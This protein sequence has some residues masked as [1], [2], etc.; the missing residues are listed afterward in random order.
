TAN[1]LED[2]DTFFQEKPSEWALFDTFTNQDQISQSKEA[3]NDK[4]QNILNGYGNNEA[5]KKPALKQ[6]FKL[7]EESPEH[8]DLLEDKIDTLL[9]EKIT[10]SPNAAES[11]K[12][13]ERLLKIFQQYQ[14]LARQDMEAEQIELQQY[15]DTM[16]LKWLMQQLSK[17]N[18]LIEL[19]Q[20]QWKNLLNQPQ[21][22]QELSIVQMEQ[23][24]ERGE[25]Q[26][27]KKKKLLEAQKVNINALRQQVLE[28]RQ[29]LETRQQQSQI[30][31]ACPQNCSAQQHALQSQLQPLTNAPSMVSTIQT[32]PPT[33]INNRRT[34]TTP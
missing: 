33:K 15:V 28:A 29:R 4:V 22:Q 23:K 11:K 20:A 7:L 12:P 24:C 14:H 8:A 9:K 19:F 1:C 10:V 30:N 5:N 34:K 21:E 18:M 13:S 16:Q 27:L 25:Q 17:Q 6:L 3:I 32:K 26:L 31:T 2:T